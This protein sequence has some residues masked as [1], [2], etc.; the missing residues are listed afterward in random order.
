MALAGCSPTGQESAHRVKTEPAALLQQAEQELAQLDA[1][2]NRAQW[3]YENYIT[4]D[5]ATLASEANLAFTQAAV[6][7]AT[8]AAKLDPTT[9]SPLDQR[10]LS[11]LLRNLI[12]PAPSDEAKSQRLAELDIE[13][14]RLYSTGRFCMAPERCLSLPQLSTVMDQ[15]RDPDELLQAWVGWRSIAPPMRPLFAEQVSLA[16]EGAEELGF[17]DVGQMWRSQYDMPADQ[18]AERVDALWLEVKPLYEALHCYVRGEL[19]E[20]YGDEVVSQSEP[21]P[22]HLLGNMWAQQWS[23]VYDLV[24]P[25]DLPG[26][27]Y[28]LTLLL[29]EHGY[30]E[31][32]MVQQAERFFTSMGFAPLPDTF[33]QR[34]LFVE[35]QDRDVVCH[36]SAWDLDNREDLRIKMCIQR[37]GEDFRVIHHE[38]G[39]NIYQRAYQHQPFLFKESANDGFHE[40]IGDVISLSITPAY[41]KQIGLLEKEPPA[42]S[43]IGLLLREAMEKV[44]FLPFGLLVDQWRWQVFSGEI[45]PSDYNQ[46][47]WDLRLEYQGVAP[48]VPR[49]ELDFDPGAKYHVPTSVPYTRY[50]LAHLLQFQLFEALCKEAGHQGP[51]HRCTL[52]GSR[53]AGEKLDAM[54]KLGLS[55]PWP[56]ALALVTGEEQMSGQAMLNYFAPLKDWLNRQNAWAGRRCGW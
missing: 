33:W 17:D 50:F 47:W 52:Y 19:G 25:E 51:I 5:T 43:D 53:E 44:A 48:P 24:A 3:I 27:G 20:V 32:K 15:S 14:N 23:N 16:N 18:F 41:L 28:D 37:T 29:S 1:E 49:S 6:R 40:A 13:L 2:A 35:P 45:A 22:A 30:D 26:P 54:L 34:S 39:H 4:T 10:K 12:L 31:L 46:A 42:E 7:H 55:Q 11:V 36:A 38:L 8:A 56:Q 9:L 21:I